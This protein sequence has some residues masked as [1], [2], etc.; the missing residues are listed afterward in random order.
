VAEPWLP[1]AEFA[2]AIVGREP[3][4]ARRI[5]LRLRAAGARRVLAEETA[6]MLVPHAGYPAALEALRALHEAWPG[7]ART[8]RALTTARVR[9]RGAALCRRVYGAVT[10][11]LLASLRTLHPDMAEWVVADGYG[12]VLSRPGMSARARELVAVAVLG[13]TGW[14]R[15]L[16]SHLR[17]ASRCGASPRELERALAA[18][19]ARRDRSTLAQ[20]A[21][22]TAFGARS[23]AERG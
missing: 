21:W 23:D 20:R 22:R 11:R 18:G 13:A 17:G 6:L 16:V 3:I 1:L 5:L 19:G 9:A 10:P 4:R 2:V 14:E 8:A 7:H 12:R 15:Q